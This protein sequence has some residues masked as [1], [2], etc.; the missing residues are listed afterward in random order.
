MFGRQRWARCLQLDFELR[1]SSLKEMLISVRPT[2]RV[3]LTLLLPL[4]RVNPQ[5]SSYVSDLGNFNL[6]LMSL[7]EHSQ[8][9]LMSARK[10]RLSKG[11]QGGEDSRLASRQED[12]I[13]SIFFC[14]RLD[15]G[16]VI[17]RRPFRT[18]SFLADAS[19]SLDYWSQGYV[20]YKKLTNWI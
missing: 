11:R 3:A 1:F 15:Y 20:K 9:S 18:S 10:E 7:K 6:R 8:R 4:R 19:F 14:G 5:Q 13:G 12:S 16:K 2:P 17:E